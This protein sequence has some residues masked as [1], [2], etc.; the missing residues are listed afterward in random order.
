MKTEKSVEGM[1]S[2][3]LYMPVFDCKYLFS[4]VQLA[5]RRC[6]MQCPRNHRKLPIL[7]VIN[8]ATVSETCSTSVPV[9]IVVD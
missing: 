7:K 4:S 3:H 9:K 2:A 6:H 1:S 5:L 8:M